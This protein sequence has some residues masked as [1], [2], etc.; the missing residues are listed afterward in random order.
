MVRPNQET[1]SLGWVVVYCNTLITMVRPEVYDSPGIDLTATQRQ[2]GALEEQTFAQ[3]QSVRT[4]QGESDSS[5]TFGSRAS[6]PASGLE[7]DRFFATDRN[8]LYYFTGTAWAFVAGLAFGTNAARAAIT[9]DASDNGA[10]FYTT[11]T[12]KLWRVS[13]GAWVDG[14]VSIDVTTSYEVGGV[15]V[16]GAQGAAVADPAGGVTVDAEARTA[17]NLVLARLRAHGLIGT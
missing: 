5:F 3:F 2:L 13:G 11:D 14:F 12:N 1:R 4:L 10:A 6:R 9:P 7:G 17:I 8:W 16:I 15:K